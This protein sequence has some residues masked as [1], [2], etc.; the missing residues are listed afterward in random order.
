MKSEL[1]LLQKLPLFRGIAPQGLETM[2][3]CF[4]G[5]FISLKKGEKLYG[6]KNR[7]VCVILGAASGLEIGRIAPMV[8]KDSPFLATEDSLVL[9]MESHMLLYPCYGCCFFHAQLLENMREDGIDF[10]A[11]NK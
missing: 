9:V 7:A 3:D 4:S 5:E 1:A 2:L 10:Q 6:E 11:F 8:A